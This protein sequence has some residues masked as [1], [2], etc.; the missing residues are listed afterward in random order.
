MIEVPLYMRKEKSLVSSIKYTLNRYEGDYA[1]FL[2]VN[3]ETVQKIIHRTEMNV[4]VAEGD[5]VLISEG[6]VIQ[7]TLLVE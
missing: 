5:I 1:I 2:M 6:P 4:E 7:I 3:D